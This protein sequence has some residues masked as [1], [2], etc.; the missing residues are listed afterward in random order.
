[1]IKNQTIDKMR[2]YIENL[3]LSIKRFLES[4]DDAMPPSKFTRID[5]LTYQTDPL[6][7]FPE[8]LRNRTSLSQYLWTDSLKIYLKERVSGVAYKRRRISL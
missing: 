4:H 6:E 1:M 7:L 3:I 2:F 5:P 8:G